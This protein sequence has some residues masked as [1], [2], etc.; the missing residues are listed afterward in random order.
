MYYTYGVMESIQLTAA[1]WSFRS[2]ELT[3]SKE[4]K[5]S[6][7][8]RKQEGAPKDATDASGEHVQEFTL[9]SKRSVDVQPT[10]TLDY[11]SQRPNTTLTSFSPS[12][13]DL[14]RLRDSNSLT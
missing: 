14:A 8:M 5:L 10:A 12:S 1:A 13:N 9:G 4:A 6:H 3:T 11:K 2:A 7:C